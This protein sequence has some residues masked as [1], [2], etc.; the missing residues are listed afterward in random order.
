MNTSVFT[1]S[2]ARPTLSPEEHTP[3]MLQ[4]RDFESLVSRKASFNVQPGHYQVA[5]VSTGRGSV[6]GSVPHDPGARRVL[7]LPLTWDDLLRRMGHSDADSSQIKSVS[8]VAEFGDIQIDFLRHETR[9]SGEPVSLTAFEF[10]V[11]KFFVSNPYRV[12]SRG[13]LLN[14]VWGYNC[15]PTTRTVD[16]QILRLRQK[17]EEEPANPVHF[18]TVY[19]AGYKFVP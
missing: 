16:N 17:L 2:V 19:G 9:R 14:T 3:F 12:V 7:L 6:D 15:Y 1:N 11:L 10:R 4:N 18:Q 5:L 13:E 8:N